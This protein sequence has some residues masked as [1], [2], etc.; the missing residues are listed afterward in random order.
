MK[1]E[2]C[3]KADAKMAVHKVVD[4]RERELYVCPECAAKA[5]GEKNPELK[6]GPVSAK[7]GKLIEGALPPPDVLGELFK[8][9][10]EPGMVEARILEN[11]LAPVEPGEPCPECGMRPDD[12]KRTGRLGCAKCYETFARQLAPMI[13]DM[14]PGAAHSGKIPVAEAPTGKRK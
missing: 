4:G 7:I 10:F 2:I 9:I 1:C 5:E 12:F 8:H 6:D 14:H 13:R 3:K 11:P